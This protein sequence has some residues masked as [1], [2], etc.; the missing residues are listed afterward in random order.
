MG[1]WGAGPF[2]NDDALD[3]LDQL[4]DLPANEL[5]GRL[6]AALAVPTEGYLEY[7]EGSAAIAAA[8][9]IAAVHRGAFDG[10]NEQARE[11][12]QT[13]AV[14]DNARLRDQA[15]AALTRVIGESSEWQA[16]WSESRSSAEADA[17]I[18]GLR[19]ALG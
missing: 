18:A 19:S 8:S 13:G 15:L 11:L 10:L 2:D 9:L 17:M 14:H 7:P 3:F 12:V 1:A 4:S 5:A 6:E 16:L